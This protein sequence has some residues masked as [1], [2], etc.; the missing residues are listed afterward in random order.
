MIKLPKLRYL[1]LIV[2]ALALAGTAWV[3][4]T[5]GMPLEDGKKLAGGRIT[6][7]V[8]DFMAAYVVE[9]ANGK[10]VLIDATMDQD[11]VAIRRTVTSLGKSLHDVIGIF[12]THGHGDH[13][14]GA[15]SL[16][17]ARVF[18]LEADADLV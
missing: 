15:W 3:V 10:L 14:A 12:I 13:I 4:M 1:L 2:I 9:L 18:A 5:G 8:D 11:A 7:A 6:M 16:P 17:H